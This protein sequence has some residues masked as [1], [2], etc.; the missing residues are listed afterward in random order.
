VLLEHGIIA[1]P[2]FVGIL[3]GNLVKIVADWT[4]AYF[5][6][7]GDSQ[8]P[9]WCGIIGANRAEEARH[10]VIDLPKREPLPAKYNG[11]GAPRFLRNAG[12][13]KQE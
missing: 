7:N 4:G 13:Y 10:P 6:E 8:T 11:C 1:R 5:A 3:T 12:R 2:S 9:L